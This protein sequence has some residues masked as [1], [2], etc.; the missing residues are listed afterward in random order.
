MIA[1]PP[2]DVLQRLLD[3]SLG[4]DEQLPIETHIE[5]CRHGNQN[6]K[7]EEQGDYLFVVLK[8]V[9]LTRLTTVPKA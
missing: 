1:C 9:E 3:E 2:R 8:L 6:A 7:V 5:D 4:P